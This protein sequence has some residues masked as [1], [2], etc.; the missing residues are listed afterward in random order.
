[1]GEG[2][3]IIPAYVRVGICK[4]CGADVYGPEAGGLPLMS[5]CACAGGR[6]LVSAAEFLKLTRER[7]EQA[8]T[9]DKAKAA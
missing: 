4:E 5:S 8:A 2:K 9:K 7:R 3:V 1:M 6:E